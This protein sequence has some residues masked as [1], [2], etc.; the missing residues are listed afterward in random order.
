[1]V[2]DEASQPAFKL[3]PFSSLRPSERTISDAFVFP[4]TDEDDVAWKSFPNDVVPESALSAMQHELVSGAQWF[5]ENSSQDME[6]RLALADFDFDAELTSIEQ[7]VASLPK[8]S[9]LDREVCQTVLA[10]CARAHLQRYP[11][12]FDELFPASITR[13]RLAT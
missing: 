2:D 1:M 10:L 9:W 7:D 12:N 4:I 3:A 6:K 5:A 11:P 8:A 13:G